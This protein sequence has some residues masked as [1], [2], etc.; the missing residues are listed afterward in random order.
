M[1]RELLWNE[2]NDCVYGWASD[3]ED[4]KD[5]EKAVKG[6]YE[7]G[8]CFVRDIEKRLCISTEKGIK[9]ETICPVEMTDIEMEWYYIATVEPLRESDSSFDDYEKD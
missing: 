8:P 5:F 9:P 3:F 4:K 1:A 6:E 2:D 7:D